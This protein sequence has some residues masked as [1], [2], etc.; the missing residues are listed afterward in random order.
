[1]IVKLENRYLLFTFEYTAYYL[2]PAAMQVL[3]LDLPTQCLHKPT[4]G[5]AIA[6]LGNTP[7][8]ILVENMNYEFMKAFDFRQ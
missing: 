5:G 6:P 7:M 1:M 8:V 3:W 4:R 2:S